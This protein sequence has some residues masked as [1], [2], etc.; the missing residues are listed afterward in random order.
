MKS[1]SAVIV[2][3]LWIGIICFFGPV[4]AKMVDGDG[5]GMA[6]DWERAVGLDTGA[7]DSREDP[8]GDGLIN[9]SEYRHGAD[10]FHGDADADGLSDKDEVDRYGTWPG[11]ADTDGGGRSDGHEVA[12]GGNPLNPDDDAAGQ[13]VSISLQAGWN[14]FSV[15]L[16][17][18]SAAVTSVLAPI[19]G[20]YKA[21]WSYDRGRWRCYDPA[22]P[23]LSDL[24]RIEAGRGYWINMK[25]ARRLTVSGEPV[26]ASM[27][28]YK[29]WNLVGYNASFAQSVETALDSLGDDCLS[30]W[31][32]QGGTWRLYD[33]RNPLYND[34]T[35]LA[36]GEGYWIETER[37]CQWR[38][39]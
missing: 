34:L 25:S 33:P 15:P 32:F 11:R 29:G 36:P 35:E 9:L 30:V 1:R 10:P 2:I 12:G 17:P 7:D 22:N 39:P 13:S 6:D 24:E 38:L 21:V 37:D 28:L 14:M 19:A 4:S 23:G 18:P 16:T 31:S 8:D 3:M 5:D 27:P 26:A 20:A